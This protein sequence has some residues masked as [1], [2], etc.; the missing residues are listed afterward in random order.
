MAEENEDCYVTFNVQEF[1][2]IF[3]KIVLVTFLL[4]NVVS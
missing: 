1:F 2:P 4:L 3:C